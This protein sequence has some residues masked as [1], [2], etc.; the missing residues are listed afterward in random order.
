M[1]YQQKSRDGSTGEGFN[2]GVIQK[3]LE[4]LK[5]EKNY[6]RT[7]LEGPIRFKL[8]CN[9]YLKWLVSKKLISKRVDLYNRILYD[10]VVKKRNKPLKR[11][12]RFYKITDKGVKFLEMIA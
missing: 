6:N 7:F 1:I 5:E 8:S 9:K 3:Y 2:V 10:E 11:P 4:L 12:H